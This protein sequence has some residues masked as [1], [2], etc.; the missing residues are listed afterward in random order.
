MVRLSPDGRLRPEAEHLPGR[1]HVVQQGEAQETQAILMNDVEVVDWLTDRPG[2]QREL[3]P[4]RTIHGPGEL[5][6]DV[7]GPGTGSRCPTTARP[8][9]HVVAGS[10]T[11]RHS[12]T[13]RAIAA[14]WGGR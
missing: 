5:G 4:S 8:R 12:A 3:T 1:F 10:G 13:L 6:Y 2:G 14:T 11:S 7:P 9:V